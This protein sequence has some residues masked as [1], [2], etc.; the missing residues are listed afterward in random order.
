MG[1]SDV[2]EQTQ[3]DYIEEFRSVSQIL[4]AGLLAREAGP[5]NPICSICNNDRIA[6]WRCRDCTCP[7]IKCRGCMRRSHFENPLHRVECWNGTYYQ[8]T[9]L[10][11]V[12]THIL[13][14]HHNLNGLC[15]SQTFQT[16]HLALMQE[17]EDETEQELLRHPKDSAPAQYFPSPANT[18]PAPPGTWDDEDEDFGD[19]P[20]TEPDDNEEDGDEDNDYQPIRPDPIIDWA[21]IVGGGQPMAPSQL[22]LAPAHDLSDP[23]AIHPTTQ[24]T[25][26]PAFESRPGSSFGTSSMPYLPPTGPAPRTDAM[27]NKYVRVV[28]TNG[29]HDIC[30]VYCTCR[31]E[32]EAQGDLFHSRLVPTS[33]QRYSTLF[34][35]VVLDDFH[36]A[37]LECKT[38]AYQYFQ[39]LRRKTSPTSP[40]TVANRYPELWR[41]SREWRWLKQTKW[42]GFAHTG[43]DVNNPAPGELTLFCPACPQPNVNLPE[44]WKVDENRYGSSSFMRSAPG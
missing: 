19:A 20:G 11:E 17:I 44:N 4:L 39:A 12:G 32:E 33:F 9:H 23:A 42:A 18:T 28:H 43:A 6:I 14:P 38:S 27:Y 8:H 35:A 10:W 13:V 7:I 36:L 2:C 31:G 15:A 34:T 40:Q 1:R 26:V 5:H 25:D 22:C 41:L 29:I 30:L 3:A 16:R 24:A 37:N 21:H